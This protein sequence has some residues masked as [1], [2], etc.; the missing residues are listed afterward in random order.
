MTNSTSTPGVVGGRLP[1]SEFE[2][3]FSSELRP[4]LTVQEAAVA[5]D[6]CYF[7][8]DAP[9]VTGCPT[10]IDIPMFIRQIS[11]GMPEAAARTIFDSNILGG[12]CAR[13]CPTEVLCE[14]VCV[15]EPSG[16]GPVEIGRLQ[17]FA[18]DRL[19]EQPAHPYD[20]AT[21]TG[22]S[23]AIVGAGPAGLA[24]AHRLAMKG[25]EVVILEARRKGG[26]LNEYGIAPYKVVEDFAAREINW[27]L[28]IGGIRLEKDVDPVDAAG[29]EQLREEFD[30]VF[31]G[32]GLN[33]VNHFALDGGNL[34]NVVNAV[35]FIADI[36]QS[37]DL[38]EIPVGRDVVVIGGGMTAI[39]AA[40]QCRL[41]GGL[42]VTIL[43][44][45][46][47]DEMGASVHEQAIAAA[48]GVNFVTDA[49]LIRIL[50]GG[51]AE[52]IEYEVTERAGKDRIGSG[53]IYTLKADLVLSAIGQRLQDAPDRLAL[54]NG[55]IKVSGNGRTSL[56]GVWAG[57]DCVAGGQDITV[58]AVAQGRDA[59]EDMHA[60]LSRPAEESGR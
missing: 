29:L 33:G 39:D 12:S 7:C 17:R 21:A 34:G 49:R 4:P 16:G 45:R 43:Y 54:K 14:Q 20:R 18:T 44:R 41:L 55:R 25:H 53:Q 31:I 3:R 9:C 23:I 1:K 15:R 19:M 51:A 10:G 50:G 48:L 26:G 46:S 37:D 40:V 42:N 30:A 2:K 57:G 22:R 58:A 32:V 47:R 36:R 11:S 8:H 5:A 52:S 28:G 24:C 56:S 60:A 35:D 6:R 27:L 13:V 59:A 38:A